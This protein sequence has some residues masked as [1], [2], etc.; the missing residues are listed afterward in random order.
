MIYGQGE[1]VCSWLGLIVAFIISEEDEGLITDSIKSL[2]STAMTKD[3]WL[4]THQNNMY[5]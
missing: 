4:I 3:I 5:V 2:E 1:T